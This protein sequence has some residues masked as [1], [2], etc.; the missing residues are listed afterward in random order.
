MKLTVHEVC[1]PEGVVCVSK[2]AN[3]LYYPVH[4]LEWKSKML[5]LCEKLWILRMGIEQRFI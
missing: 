3:G 5:E 1:N 2:I 4:M